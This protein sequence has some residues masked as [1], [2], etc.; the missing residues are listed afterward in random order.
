MSA[1]AFNGIDGATGAYLFP[2]RTP[3]EVA[4]GLGGPAPLDELV[5]AAAAREA[6]F[7]VIYGPD[8]ERLDEAGWGVVFPHGTPPQVRDALAPLLE[9]RALEAGALYRE[10]ELAPGTSK[11]AFLAAHGMGPNPADPKRVPY[12]LLLVGGDEAVP[13]EFQYELDGQYAVGRLAFDT[14]GDYRSYAD[15]V[16]RAEAS[17]APERRTLELFA[18]SRPS[19]RPTL[20]SALQLAAPLREELQGA[21][22]W[23]VNATIG[24]GATKARLTSLLLDD[25]PQLLLTAGHGIGFEAGD[26]RRAERQGALVT[27][28]WGGPGTPISPEQYFSA[29]DLPPD[30]PVRAQIIFAFACFGVATTAPALLSRLPQRL[31]A[32]GALAFVGHVDRA[33]GCS[34]T[35]PDAGT[36]RQH[37]VSTL[38]ALRDGWRVG[39]AKEFFDLRYM[40]VALSLNHLLDRV[41]RL[42]DVDPVSIA[43]LWTATHDARNYVVLGDP[44]VRLPPKERTG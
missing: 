32:G 22:G 1:L 7:G 30:R 41:R 27:Q 6:H 12:Y 18:P 28:D 20:L 15:A 19:D 26:R 35:F 16:I 44:A 25:G 38:S 23:T 40:D 2:Q 13:F 10:F 3:E 4:A 31:L 9:L 39:H 34:Y 17:I 5:Y 42:E 8:A 33:L 21:D 14:A 36:Q 29:A 43:S 24:E 11:Q 37:F